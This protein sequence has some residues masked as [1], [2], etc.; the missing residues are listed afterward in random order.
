MIGKSPA[1]SPGDV[2]AGSTRAFMPEG[3]AY[4]FI[5]RLTRIGGGGLTEILLDNGRT[6]FVY[7]RE[8]LTV[9]ERYSGPSSAVVKM[10]DGSWMLSAS[11]L[12]AA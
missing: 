4:D 6:C 9:I 10:P 12:R 11:A 1:P 3:K 8:P 5:G 2:V 7:S